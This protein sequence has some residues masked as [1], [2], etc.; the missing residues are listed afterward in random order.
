MAGEVFKSEF[1]HKCAL[2]PQ[3]LCVCALLYPVTVQVKA[4]LPQVVNANLNTYLN[5]TACLLSP[6]PMEIGG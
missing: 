5:R 1:K 3:A 6:A 4:H 2:L